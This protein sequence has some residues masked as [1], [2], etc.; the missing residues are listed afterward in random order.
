MQCSG[1]K[2][3]LKVHLNQWPRFLSVAGQTDHL[4]LLMSLSYYTN[5]QGWVSCLGSGVSCS[6]QKNLILFSCCTTST[7]ETKQTNKQRKVE[8]SKVNNARSNGSQR[9]DPQSQI[10]SKRAVVWVTL[11]KP[12]LSLLAH[13]TVPNSDNM[14][15]LIMT[16]KA[17]TVRHTT[18]VLTAMFYRLSNVTFHLTKLYA[19]S[20]LWIFHSIPI[21]R[22]CGA[23]ELGSPLNPSSVGEKRVARVE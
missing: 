18:A 1:I 7:Q 4:G 22:V 19:D 6:V 14:P 23:S 13:S 3:L 16:A 5:T 20:K 12:S 2:Y 9:K 15:S 11:W 8:W 21:E 17:Q 10:R